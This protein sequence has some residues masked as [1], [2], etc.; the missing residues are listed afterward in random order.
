MKRRRV[1]ELGIVLQ[2]VK[3]SYLAAAGYD[4]KAKVM[5]VQFK[6]GAQGDYLAVQPGEYQDF[7][8]AQS[9]GNWLAARI[10]PYHEWRSLNKPAVAVKT[11]AVTTPLYTALL[12]ARALVGS[13]VKLRYSL[14]VATGKPDLN[15][16][17]DAAKLYRHALELCQEP[18]A[19]ATAKAMIGR[20]LAEARKEAAK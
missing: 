2:P 9:K 6:D 19:L 20:G 17:T 12:K 4:P 13:G 5:R 10:K 14:W 3:S 11:V 8:T 7:E 18:T 15:S 16:N 1:V